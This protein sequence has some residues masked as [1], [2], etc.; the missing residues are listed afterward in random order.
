MWAQE[1]ELMWEY[2]SG[3]DVVPADLSRLKRGLCKPLLN[4]ALLQRSLQIP[5]AGIGS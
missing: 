3:K 1:L 5:D 2:V 4:L